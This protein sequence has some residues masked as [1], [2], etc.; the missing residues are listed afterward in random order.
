MRIL[1]VGAHP[2]DIEILCA[3]TLA[4]YAAAGHEVIMAHLCNGDCGHYEIPPAE[5]A[6]IRAQEAQAAAAILGAEL[7]TLPKVGDGDL[8]ADDMPTRQAVADLI[9]RSRP[10][11]IIT[12]DPDDYMPDH[13]A[14]SKLIFDA[15]FLATLPAWPQHP[16]PHHNVVPP[17]YFMDTLAGVGFLPEEYVDISETFQ[18]KRR[19]L[20]CHQSQL[21]WLKEH[22]DID[23][24]EFMGVLSRLRGLQ[25]GVQ[26]AEGFKP[27]RVWPRLGT[28]RL[29]P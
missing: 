14:A 27:L 4:R 20:E 26:Y 7:L 6:A 1:A 19:M 23:V 12:H 2:D 9:R 28:Q 21:T 17:V 11:L 13:R 18:L 29:L 15:S 10:D 16:A 3:G 25:A 22:D 8:L 24:L 5:L